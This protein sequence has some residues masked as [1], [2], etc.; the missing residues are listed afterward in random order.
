MKRYK[1]II[2]IEEDDGLEETDKLRAAC[3]SACPGKCME[4]CG[5]D[6]KVNA[7]ADAAMDNR[8]YN[9]I[10]SLR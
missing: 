8:I 6:D 7:T 4:K 3:T 1:T 10:L 5:T 9:V 2:D